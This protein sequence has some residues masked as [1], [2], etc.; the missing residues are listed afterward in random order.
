M[1]CM[2]RTGAKVV[3]PNTA[4]SPNPHFLCESGNGRAAG[5][6]TLDLF[7]PNEALYQAEP[8]PVD[9]KRAT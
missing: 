6:R 5:I 3:T 4:P 8:Q 7:D 9:L 2:M 1:D